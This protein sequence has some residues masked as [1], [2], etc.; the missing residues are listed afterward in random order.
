MQN[1]SALI[2]AR[3]ASPLL[4]FFRG[5]KRTKRE[6]EEKR[7]RAACDRARPIIERK[8]ERAA[9]YPVAPFPPFRN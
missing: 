4:L 6:R 9:V 3:F 7:E 8:E 5:N 1:S 2:R